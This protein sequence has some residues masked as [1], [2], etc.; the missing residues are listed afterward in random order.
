MALSDRM[1]PSPRLSARITSI[2]Y[3]T[4]TTRISDQKIRLSMP[5]TS[6]GVTRVPMIWMVD[7]TA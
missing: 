2:T 4:V 6:P 3:F 1:P 7:F 5:S